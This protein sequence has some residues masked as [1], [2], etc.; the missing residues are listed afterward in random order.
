[1]KEKIFPGN[2][3]GL[4]K[5]IAKKVIITILLLSNGILLFSFVMPSIH[6][7]GRSS[8]NYILDNVLK[9][10]GAKNFVTGIYLDYRLFDSL[11][12]ASVLFVV[13]AGVLFMSKKDEEVR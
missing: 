1:M 9:D 4:M 11:L 3:W 2:G 10:V 5:N 13:T 12:E 6:E 8:Y 7:K